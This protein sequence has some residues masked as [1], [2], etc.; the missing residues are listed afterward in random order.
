M[1]RVA[2]VED[3]DLWAD[4]LKE[5]LQ[6]LGMEQGWKFQTVRFRDGYELVDPYPGD[7]DFIL[8]DIEMGL[9]N[10]ME[11]AEQVRQKDAGIPILFVT[12]APQYALQGYRVQAMDY[13]LK[14]I[15]YVS[16]AESVKRAVRSAEKAGKE[17]L[18]VPT[19]NMTERIPLSEICWIESNRHRITFCLKDRSVETTVFSMKE[20]E[21]RLSGKDFVRC[22]SGVLVNLRHVTG[23]KDNELIV[24][25]TA[26][27]V[28]RG[29]K[30]ACMEALL[31]YLNQ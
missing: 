5:Y 3:E 26:L 18:S 16:F 8:M 6:K 22:S 12:N 13:I 7:L 30:A 19:K 28:S 25:G 14:P 27:S 4:I 17:S 31:S 10:G 15:A 9:M 24:N 29:R 23:F 1:I 11:A 21:E 2:I 20:L